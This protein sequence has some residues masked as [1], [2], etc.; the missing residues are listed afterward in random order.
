MTVIVTGASRGIGRSVADRLHSAGHDVLGIAL[1][2]PLD[3]NYSVPEYPIEH[4]DVSNIEN[5]YSV[6]E[7]IKHKKISGLINCAGVYESLPF[8]I[9]TR[10][11]YFDIININLLGTMNTCS[12]FLKLMDKQ[13]HTPIINVSSI[14]AH[15]ANEATAYT[16]SKY[17][18]EGFTSSLARDLR[19]TMIRPNSICPGVIDTDM[20]S[21]VFRDA[22][23]LQSYIDMQPI[24]IQ[25]TVEDVADVVELLFD[26][27]SNKIGGQAIRLG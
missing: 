2:S 16:A 21:A 18:V 10:D 20:Y 24:G 8:S 14:A 6:Y 19:N 15:S 9:L 13:V 25:L 17:G 1:P 26:S 4:A 23:I 12:V 3:S 11:K 22:P 7:K 27:R 5:L